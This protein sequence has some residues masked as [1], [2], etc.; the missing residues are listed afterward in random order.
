MSWTRYLFHDFFTASELNRIDDR[1]RSQRQR[2]QSN[3]RIESSVREHQASRIA[4]LEDELARLSLLTHA[5]AEAC[6]K[7]GA[8]Q[9]EDLEAIIEQIDA[10]DGVVDGKLGGQSA[11]PNATNE[12]AESQTPIEF[13]SDLEKKP[14]Q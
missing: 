3:R 13:L 5:L 14:P 7:N 2:E 11:N 10:S 4:E 8:F 6:L 12:N 9:R 1:I